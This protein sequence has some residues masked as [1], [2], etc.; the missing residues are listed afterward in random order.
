MNEDLTRWLLDFHEPA[1]TYRVLTELL[2][3]PV[4]DPQVTA[5]KAAIPHSDTVIAIF[6]KMH[7]DYYWENKDYKGRMLGSGR[8]YS[9]QTTHFVL[10]YL[11]EVGMD[12]S[13]E[14]YEKSVSRY[15]DLQY[16]DGTWTR[17]Q[18]CIYA[19][20]IYSFV[21]LGFFGDPR[22]QKTIDY[23]LSIDRPDGGYLCDGHEGKYKNKPT[24]SCVKGCSKALLAFTVL[25]QYWQ[26]RACLHLVQ[27]FLDH[28]ILWKMEHPDEFI[29][30]SVCAFKY[31]INYNASLWE[32]MYALSYM[33]YG[34]HPRMQRA[35]EFLDSRLDDL[36]RAP[37]DWI[38]TKSLWKAG[39]R[40][41]PNPWMTFYVH[42]AYKYRE[43]QPLAYVDLE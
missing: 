7:P 37:L 8:E 40:G 31:P 28:E 14:R 15:L 41:E 42:L 12:R 20:N 1:L 19:Q 34:R 32:L 38:Q 35:W 5:A 6:A 9:A 2:D 21:K 4:V 10:G 16:E 3:K 23:L 29:H 22:L 30:A 11:A 18:S 36:G 39:K 33:G 26:H 24:K 17:H 25:P 43:N 13:D 27:Y